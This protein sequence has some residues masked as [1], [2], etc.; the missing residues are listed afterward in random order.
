MQPSPAAGYTGILPSLLA[1][2]LWVMT[3]F[4]APAET[5]HQEEG[6]R[7]ATDF[8]M[9]IK[10]SFSD[11]KQFYIYIHVSKQR[12]VSLSSWL[13]PALAPVF[14]ETFGDVET[15]SFLPGSV[16]LA[17]QLQRSEFMETSSWSCAYMTSCLGLQ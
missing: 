3:K 15:E 17:H 14:P 11:Q 12:I 5:V 1:K 13:W 8:T 10:F 2:L 16:S 4:R 6:E 9:F 7:D